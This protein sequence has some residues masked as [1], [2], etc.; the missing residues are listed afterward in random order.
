MKGRADAAT[1]SARAKKRDDVVAG[2]F[3]ITVVF[4][5]TS[6]EPARLNVHQASHA[7]LVL[8]V[9]DRNDR[10][11]LLPPPS[12]PDAEDLDEGQLIPPG[13]SISIDYLGFLDRSLAPGRAA[14]TSRAPVSL[15]CRTGSSSG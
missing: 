1:R 10:E 9:R 7:A 13:E 4:A 11:V 8:D 14:A 15:S 5:K 2:E 3:G 6:A 12:A